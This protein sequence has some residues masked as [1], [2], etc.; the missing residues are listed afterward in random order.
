[1]QAPNKVRGD[2]LRQLDVCRKKEDLHG[3]LL[4]FERLR[5]SYAADKEQKRQRIPLKRYVQVLSLCTK[6]GNLK[7]MWQLCAEI[8]SVYGDEK[9]FAATSDVLIKVHAAQNIASALRLHREMKQRGQRLK[10]R[11]YGPIIVACCQ[12]QDR[13]NAFSLYDEAKAR[14]IDFT[15]AEYSELIHL[16]VALKLD[17][18]M[19]ALLNDISSVFTV[20]PAKLLGALKEWFRSKMKSLTGGLEC[21]LKGSLG[22]GV[23]V[24]PSHRLPN[25][26]LD[27]YLEQILAAQMSNQRSRR[28]EKAVV[29]AVRKFLNRLA[30]DGGAEIWIDGANVGHFE[31]GGSFSYQQVDSVFSH[32]V[33]AGY[34]T[35]LVLHHSRVHGLPS[36]SAEEK[37]VRK[38]T[39]GGSLYITPNGVN[40]DAFWM[41]GAIWSSKTQRRVY[42]VS[43]DLG[44]DHHYRFNHDPRFFNF[45]QAH[46]I[47]FRVKD[48]DAKRW[49]KMSEDHA[50]SFTPTVHKPMPYRPT[51]PST[52]G[53]KHKIHADTRVATPNRYFAQKV[54]T[55]S[56]QSTHK[57]QFR[58][59]IAPIPRAQTYAPGR[60][61][62][63][64]KTN[65]IPLESQPV[66]YFKL[67][68][69]I[70]PNVFPLEY[71]YPFR[72]KIAPQRL[73]SGEWA[74]PYLAKEFSG[75]QKDLFKSEDGDVPPIPATVA[76]R[77]RWVVVKR[78]R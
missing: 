45:M 57:T 51:S 68:H 10:R 55:T 58:S 19:E 2:L 65:P 4:A 59:I 71:H 47:R 13:E 29:R 11:S 78:G 12:A 54:R 69:F 26:L 67:R 31:M 16:C 9:Y 60:Y 36:N 42:I 6:G 37:I 41:Y 39:T 15:G 70:A 25:E 66:P 30:R 48:V 1:M 46:V 49:K 74:F 76:G 32:F 38:W 23:A 34:R 43:N 50:P 64:A 44:R 56:Y 62:A 63:A 24:L 72:Y 27:E 33:R 61:M 52:E 20:L 14:G 35:R 17:K 77:V 5:K 22:A 8:K 3:A 73:L 53:G 7:Q 75:E 40:D 28:K 18:D 21:D